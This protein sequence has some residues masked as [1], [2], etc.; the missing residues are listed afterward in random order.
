MTR[1]NLV[2][3]EESDTLFDD[4]NRKYTKLFQSIGFSANAHHA[5]G[6]KDCQK[7]IDGLRGEARVH[8]VVS[9]IVAGATNV[10]RGLLWIQQLKKSFPDILFIGNS[11]KEVTHKETAVKYPTFDLYVDKQLLGRRSNAQYSQQIGQEILSHFAQDTTVSIS[12]DSV[13]T[14]KFL[15]IFKEGASDRSLNSLMCQVFF[16]GHGVDHS[17]QPKRIKLTPLAGGFSGSFVFKVSAEYGASGLKSIPSVLKISP[18]QRA[19]E[20]AA[21]Y[22][23]YVK[24]VL[25]YAWRVD[26]LGQGTTA[27]W[28]AVCYSFIRSDDVG[29]DNVTSF[30]EKEETDEVFSVIN[31]IFSPTYRTWYSPKLVEK[32]EEVE[33][34]EYYSTEYF[35]S[36]EAQIK[37]ASF[38]KDKAQSLL[39]AHIQNDIVN[40]PDLNIQVPEPTSAL[41]PY[42][43]GA[44]HTTI[45]HGDLNSNN[46]LLAQNRE[47]VFIDFQNTGRKHVFCDF[48]V[49]EQ[50]IRLSFGS[51]G[52]PFEDML[53]YEGFVS[54]LDNVE[55]RD[56]VTV[57][58]PDMY[59]LI[60]AMRQVAVKNFENEPFEN[61]LFGATVFSLRLLRID[62]FSDEQYLRIM[63][64]LISGLTRIKI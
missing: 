43:R 61:Y 63:S 2:I 10:K 1:L 18:R 55:N 44:F 45:S 57:D 7:L 35:P 42:G 34:A 19:S 56:A 20:E 62:D 33:L 52:V 49:F 14:E 13:F 54:D 36:D 30:L 24:W 51:K 9:D 8:V 17:M 53:R 59:R 11:G 26:L 48:I 12:S 23:K 47:T 15:E 22:Q 40:F 37:A 64:Q 3:I 6:Q 29:F 5:T 39:N 31:K 25:P 28:G 16:T 27:K 58:L 46:I 21:N 4:L 41:F 38:F 50:S 32:S 60:L